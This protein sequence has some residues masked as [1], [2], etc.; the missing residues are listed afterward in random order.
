MRDNIDIFGVELT[1]DGTRHIA[2]PDIGRSLFFDHQE[3]QKHQCVNVLEINILTM[4]KTLLTLLA[5]L[6]LCL[7]ANAQKKNGKTLVAYV[8]MTGQTAQAA[9]IL[10]EV[11]GGELYEVEPAERYSEADLDWRDQNSRS[12]VEM[13]NLKSRPALKAKKS[14][15]AD[16]D[17]IYLGFPIWWNLAPTLVNSFVEVHNLSGK[18]LIPFATSGGS[19]IANSVMELKKAYPNLNWQDGML[20]N[21]MDKDTIRQ[22]VNR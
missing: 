5:I 3:T 10:A 14:N 13:H 7:T 1:D 4:K 20:L 19:K 6:S 22:L 16:Y 18:T 15:I 9:Q 21:G 2:T 12:Y 17:T 11:T 8:S